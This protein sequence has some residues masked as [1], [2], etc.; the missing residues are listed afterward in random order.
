MTSISYSLPLVLAV[1]AGIAGCSGPSKG[2]TTK[3]AATT[4]DQQPGR[5]GVVLYADSTCQN[6]LDTNCCEVEKQCDSNCRAI[7]ACVNA[8][9]VPKTDDCLGTCAGNFDQTAL[10]DI[11]SCSKAVAPPTGSSC[12]WP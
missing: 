10:D 9:P 3:D 1:G 6:W 4:A 2:D 12:T 11:A 8:C 7:I 5:C